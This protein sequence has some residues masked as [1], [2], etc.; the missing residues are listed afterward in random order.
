MAFNKKGLMKSIYER[1]YV[2]AGEGMRKHENNKR[3]TMN[4][5]MA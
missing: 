4:E 2:A 5:G 1:P 3:E